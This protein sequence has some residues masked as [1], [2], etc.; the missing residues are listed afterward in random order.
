MKSSAIKRFTLVIIATLN[1]L[2]TML[3]IKSSAADSKECAVYFGTG[4]HGKSKGIYLGILNQETGALSQ[5]VLAALTSNPGFLDISTNGKYLYATGGSAMVD[6][7]QSDTAV[8]FA[9]DRKTG[10][11]TELNTVST[12][13]QGPCHILL[14]KTSSIA[15]VANYGSGSLVSFPIGK[16]GKLGEA[17]SFFQNN[18]KS[19]NQGRQEG[20]H[21]HGFAVDPYNHFA[22]ACDL[23]IDKVLIF[24]IDTKAKKLVPNEIPFFS[25]KPGSGPR[26]I[27]FRP[28]GKF[29]YVV[30]ELTSTV[31]AASVDANTG[32]L[33]EIQ[34]I[35][36]LPSD[37][38]QISSAAEI[39]CHPSGKFLYASN[40]GH[41]SIAVFAIDPATG[42]LESIQHQSTLGKTP[43]GFGVDPSGNFL[44]VANQDSENVTVMRIDQDTGKLQ[45]VGNPL[46]VCAGMCVLFQQL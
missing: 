19:I 44:I 8:A 7:K 9:I 14:D 12:V 36:M 1:I 32:G 46:T 10:L 35:S 2:Q 18:G 39:A 29:V 26:H 41:D 38:T 22:Y 43:R 5:P 20:P 25:I 24:H 30:N 3:P 31:T 4:T 11:L 45:P 37:F 16:G 17:S 27:T 42:K 21:A 40:R 23:G 15:M 6:G 28:D 34:T 33:N 13:G